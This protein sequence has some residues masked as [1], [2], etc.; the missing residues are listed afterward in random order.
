MAQ[1]TTPGLP[2]VAHPAANPAPT[3]P[4]MHAV[5]VLAGLG[6][7]LLGPILPILA[8]N[9]HLRDSQSG[10]LLLAQFCGATVGGATVS[11]RLGRDLFAGL[12][13]AAAGFF[14]F[15]LA[16]AFPLACAGLVVGGFGVGRTIASVNIL[17]GQ[18]ATRQRGSALSRLNFSWSL[19]ALLS[20]LLAAWLVPHFALH[21][22]L[23]A[24]AALFLSASA[25]LA[26]QMRQGP[27]ETAGE[28]SGSRENMPASAE[29]MP[30]IFIYFLLMLFLY[31]G[32]E[33]CLSGWL[34]TYALR[35][36]RTS[37]VLSEYTMVLLLAGLTAGRALAARLLLKVQDTTL[38]RIALMLTAMLTVGLVLAQRSSLIATLAVLL[39]V[40]VAPVFPA[41][42]SIY[43]SFRPPARQAG[44]VLAASGIGAAALPWAM[45]VISTR[46]GSLRVALALPVSAALAMLVQSRFGP[47][48]RPHASQPAPS[49][50]INER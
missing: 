24:F 7:M 46:S 11:S 17:A 2:H 10:L 13:S 4:L 1:Q 43:M 44:L 6:T 50:G 34:T 30:R 35:F 19:G 47:G 49:R 27:A 15:A 41:S 42:F 23:A 29:S 9:W 25:V 21:T 26:L 37:L 3:L 18:R 28:A 22:L 16:P 33:T 40:C 32:L 38:L 36:G 14:V 45:G 31:G 39:G 20:P 8:A 5:F 12:A 48:S